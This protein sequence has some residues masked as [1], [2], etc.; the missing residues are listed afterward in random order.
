MG[1]HPKYNFTPT[2]DAR[3]DVRA[4]LPTEI[5][6][7]FAAIAFAYNSAE[8]AIDE[9]IAISLRTVYPFAELTSRINGIDG[10][11]EVLKAVLRMNGLSPEVQ[12]S[13]AA[14]LGDAGFGFVK[15]T[16]DEI[17]HSVAL[18]DGDARTAAK[19]G[20]YKKLPLSKD[21]LEGVLSRALIINCEVTEIK[22]ICM[23]QA[24]LI[25]DFS[26]ATCNGATSY[27]NMQILGGDI[28][29]TLASAPLSGEIAKQV[30]VR[31][32]LLKAHQERRLS[33]ARLPEID[34]DVAR[35]KQRLP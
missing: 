17:I 35:T 16:R 13:I 29:A 25:D 21:F 15:K 20:R 27:R 31:L 22:R 18:D 32:S 33:L 19:R 14:S 24:D 30:Q 23:L 4:S 1:D 28:P 10:R 6:N 34:Y 2:E 26:Q 8:N 12:D 11:I 3:Y 7:T 5:L 9:S